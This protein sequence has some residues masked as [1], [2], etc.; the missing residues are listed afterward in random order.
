MK[1]LFIEKQ[2]VLA[3]RKSFSQNQ[4]L[5]TLGI[6]AH[7]NSVSVI[8]NNIKF[9]TCLLTRHEAESYIDFGYPFFFFFFFFFFALFCFLFCQ[10]ISEASHF[11]VK[12]S[13]GSNLVLS[14]GAFEKHFRVCSR[15]LVIAVISFNDCIYVCWLQFYLA[16]SQVYLCQWENSVES[17]F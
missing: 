2:I 8:E 11:V 3:V 1:K 9:K 10:G 17:F 7:S 4:R 14:C 15:A 6:I 12:V 5:R 16:K 13:P